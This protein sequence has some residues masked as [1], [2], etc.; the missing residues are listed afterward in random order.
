M[1]TGLFC[2]GIGTKTKMEWEGIAAEFADS[3]SRKVA[4]IFFLS[5]YSS[6]LVGTRP[7]ETLRTT[8]RI[9]LLY[10]IV[11]HVPYFQGTLHPEDQRSPSAP[12]FGRPR[13][14]GYE[15]R[16]LTAG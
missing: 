11:L 12:I 4:R 2:A 1:R 15:T 5:F 6:P 3:G 10:S 13:N 8:T 7:T 9:L 16:W 14:L